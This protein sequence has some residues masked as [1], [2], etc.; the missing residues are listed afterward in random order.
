M[1]FYVPAFQQKQKHFLLSPLPLNHVHKPH[2]IS[3]HQNHFLL[4]Q[5]FFYLGIHL[6]LTL[7]QQYEKHFLLLAPYQF[8]QTTQNPWKHQDQNDHFAF[9]FEKM[10]QILL[11]YEYEHAHLAQ[12]YPLYLQSKHFEQYLDIL[13]LFGK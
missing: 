12:K 9:L 10:Q 5:T 11:S 2:E 7:L 1:Q 6:L 13:I 4:Q 8:F 3:H